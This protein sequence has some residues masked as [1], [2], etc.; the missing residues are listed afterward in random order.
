MINSPSFS[1]FSNLGLG[2]RCRW[3]HH[4]K[5]A[6]SCDSL[7]VNPGQSALIHNDTD[8]QGGALGFKGGRAGGWGWCVPG[9][10]V[11]VY[12]KVNVAEMT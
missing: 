5:F 3:I 12:S 2:Q 11:Q 10:K 7:L 4:R 9:E 1:S 8:D 6:G